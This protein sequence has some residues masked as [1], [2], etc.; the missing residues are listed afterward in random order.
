M[1]FVGEVLMHFCSDN[2]LKNKYH[3]LGNEIIRKPSNRKELKTAIFVNLFYEEDCDRYLEYLIPLVEVIDVYVF[4]SNKLILEIV[5]RKCNRIVTK[6]KNNRGRDISAFLVTAKKY[7]CN[8]DLIC[9]LHD[10]KHKYSHLKNDTDIWKYGMWDNL[11]GTIDS[12]T[13]VISIFESDS[14]LGA[15]LPPVPIGDFYSGWFGELWMNNYE[16]TVELARKL[17]LMITIEKSKQPKSVGT[18]FWARTKALEKLF[19]VKWGY[20]SFDDEPLP[21]DGTLSHAIE[22]IISY[23][24]EDAG[25]SADYVMSNNY[26]DWLLN[27][28]EKK[29]RDVFCFLNDELQIENF[30]EFYNMSRQKE[31]VENFCEKYKKVYLYGAGK[32]GKK[33]LHSMSKWGLDPMGFV[34]TNRIPNMVLEG[35]NVFLIDELDIDEE[36]GFIISVNLENQEEL[37]LVLDSKGVKNYIFGYI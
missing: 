2:S 31:L 5:N 33:L 6:I 20:D 3:I 11:V 26:S 19:N 22:R 24:V 13:R 4:S 7:I 28:I 14:Q 25:F 10:K 30:H 34:V 9:F 29:L 23:V 21:N 16:N 17:G 27:D 35:K 18:M 12:V 15:L 8:Y 37:R 1:L 36:T 32:Y